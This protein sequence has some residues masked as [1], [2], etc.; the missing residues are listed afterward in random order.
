MT[1]TEMPL[2]SPS[3]ERV[4]ATQVVA[5]MTE[6][7]RRHGVTLGNY[8]DLHAWS[9]AHRDL[10]WDLAWDIFDVVGEK[11]SRRLIDG[12]R[13]PGAQFFPDARLNFAQNLLR[14]ADDGVAMIFRGEDKARWQ[15]TWGELNVL[16]SRLQQALRA[17]SIG[18]GDRVAAMLPNLPETIAAMLAVASIGAI[19][20]SCSPD[21]GERG[22]LDRF[23]QIEPKAFV[24]V[25]GYWYNG[26]PVRIVDKLRPIVDQLSSAATVVTTRSPAAS[27]RTPAPPR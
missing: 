15:L 23:G 17:A 18:P 19:W 27:C 4:A 26:K 14:R 21:F 8:R 10:F 3:P 22:V 16:V 24:T 1:A 5:F 2:W 9:V 25:D 13:M 7:S 12:D 6:V 20:S 11:G